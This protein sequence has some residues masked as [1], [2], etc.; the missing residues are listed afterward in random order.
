MST[1]GANQNIT[2]TVTDVAGRTVSTTVQINLEAS[3]LPSIT[4]S[5]SP[6]PNARGWN[7]SS[8]TVS[9]ICTPAV[10]PISQ[11]PSSQ[12]VTAQGASQVV[13]GTVTDVAGNTNT[14]Q[15]TVNISLTPPTIT[16]SVSPLAN[17]SGWTNIPPTVSFICNGPVAP[18]AT[19]PTRQQISRNGTNL[20]VTGTVTDF[21]GATAT[22]SVVLNV[23]TTP[24]ML[25]I[26]SPTSG[27]NFTTGQVTVQGL[28]S[29]ALSGVKS[30]NCGSVSAVVA[31]GAFSCNVAL[32]AGSNTIGITATDVA[33]NSVTSNLTLLLV[34]PIAVQIATPASLQLFSSN[35]VTVTGT[36]SDPTSSVTVGGITATLNGEA[37]SAAGVTLQEGNNLLTAS[38][39]SPSGGIG[40]DTVSVYLDTTPPKVQIDNPIAG[41]VVTSSQIDVTGGV[42]D[43]VTGTVNGDQVS[44]VVNGV[45][46]TVS[47]RSFAAHGV[48]LVPGLNTITA[49]ATDRAGNTNQNQVQVT[50]QQLAGQTLSIISGNDQSGAIQTLLPQPLV[51]LATDALGRAMANVT[52]SFSVAKSDGFIISGQQRGRQLTVQTG[53]NGQASVQF[54]LGSRTGAGINQVAVSSPGFVGQIVFSEDTTVGVPTFIHTVSG[55]MQVGAVG[56]ALAQPLVAIVFDAGGNPVVNVPVTFSVKS[57]GG[58]IGGASSSVLNTDSDG[59]AYAVLVLGQQEGINNNTV[60]A[61]FAGMTGNNGNALVIFG[62]KVR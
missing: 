13:S 58:L 15:A 55:E 38:A 1:D 19:C 35:P 42:N 2:G 45:S 37:F 51:V 18:I 20:A 6:S 34:K 39:T 60:T 50:L 8:V 4:A 46:A 26:T 27:S 11:C 57:G 29:D 31:G 3:T 44:V 16:A 56:V 36:V 28:V 25:S 7:S 12:T 48:L 10:A 17:G 61:S 41:A 47:N 5:V 54:Q 9:F 23:D 52:L 22:T 59:K 49:L 30:V 33:G 14:A 24:P 32:L 62:N 53:T 21:A 40:S 43:M